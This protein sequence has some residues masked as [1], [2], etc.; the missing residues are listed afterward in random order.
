MSIEQNKYFLYHIVPKFILGKKILPLSMLKKSYTNIEKIETNKL[1]NEPTSPTQE[2]TPLNCN[3]R[4]VV[5]TTPIAPNL[6]AEEY[7]KKTGNSISKTKFYKIDISSLDI[8]KLCLYK[9]DSNGQGDTFIPFDNTML[10]N[11]KRFSQFQCNNKNTEDYNN[12]YTLFADTFL[13]LYKGAID[14]DGCD[15]IEI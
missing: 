15:I 7:F 5:F 8:T 14:I 4:D 9:T 11:F 6:L 10:E 2:I 1:S 12:N 3:R 13:F